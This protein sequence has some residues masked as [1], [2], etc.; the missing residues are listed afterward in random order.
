MRML[1][2]R[3]RSAAGPSVLAPGKA[4]SFTRCPCAQSSMYWTL[5]RSWKPA[6]TRRSNRGRTDHERPNHL[7]SARADHG[8]GV[9]PETEPKSRLASDGSFLGARRAR[10]R[11]G[12]C[13]VILYLDAE[14]RCTFNFQKM[15]PTMNFRQAST[16]PPKP[17][18]WFQAPDTVVLGCLRCK[19]L[20]SINPKLHTIL[21]NGDIRPSW[22]C[23]EC[24]SHT[25]VHLDGYDRRGCQ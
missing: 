22:T 9:R 5:S 20:Y 1:V 15:A 24:V 17:G 2:F 11:A 8:S 3:V 12:R 10:R 18:E 13:T 7:R 23:V 16:F 25:I 14:R 21:S 4:L 6:T 19:S